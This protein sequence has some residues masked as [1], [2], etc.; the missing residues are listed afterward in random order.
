MRVSLFLFCFLFLGALSALGQVSACDV[1]G[2][3]YLTQKPEE[4]HIRIY[5]AEN[6]KLA[7]VVVYKQH[8]RLYATEAGQWHITTKKGWADVIMYITDERYSA[9]FTVYFT[10]T[11][12]FAGCN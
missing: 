2:S 6:E 3:V 4:A 5:I 9:N 1:F 8:N 11:E 12:E 7:N 10:D